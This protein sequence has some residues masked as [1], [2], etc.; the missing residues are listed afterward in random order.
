MDIKKEINYWLESAKHDLKTAEVLFENKK[1]DWCLFIG[2][3]IIEKVLKAFYIK[4]NHK[5]PPKIHK[6]E[7]IAEK[8]IDFLKEINNFNIEARYPNG[9]LEFYK[10]CT[11]NFTREY[12]GKIKELYKCL[13]KKIGS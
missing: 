3:L 7:V 8:E 4:K 9:K 11:K 1:Y 10:L 6:L 13:I 5:M 12:F 2:H